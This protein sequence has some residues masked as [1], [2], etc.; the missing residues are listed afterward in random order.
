MDWKRLLH[1]LAA[2][3]AVSKP[4]MVGGAAGPG[5]GSADVLS[6]R[7]AGESSGLCVR[8]VENVLGSSP[9]TS[10]ATVAQPAPAKPDAAPDAGVN[11]LHP[12]A[13]AAQRSQPPSQA[14]SSADA[15][16]TSAHSDHLNNQGTARLMHPPSIIH[17]A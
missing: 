9:T 15:F 2:G 8:M 17:L 12:P 16:F 7:S 11:G 14:P 5:G 6:P 3:H 10:A 1:W 13:S 4:I